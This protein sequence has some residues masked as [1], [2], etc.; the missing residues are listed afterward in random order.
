[1]E[2][3]NQLPGMFLEKTIKFMINKEKAGWRLIE[4][5]PF[6]GIEEPYLEFEKPLRNDENS[7]KLK[8]LEARCDIRKWNICGQLHAEGL[9]LI[10]KKIPVKL[11]KF[12]ILFL[13]TKWGTVARF[14]VMIPVMSWSEEKQEWNVDFI[15]AEV[16][17]GHEFLVARISS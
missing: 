3:T 7:I 13:G 15:S 16:D 6:G 11:R 17:F 10:Q 4:N 5:V 9:V 12:H 1:M 14:E 8:P 2:T